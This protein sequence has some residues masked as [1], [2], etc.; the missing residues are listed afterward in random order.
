M[1]ESI[2]SVI[3][4]SYNAAKY[5]PQAINSVLAQT[6]R[7]FEIIV[8]DDGSTDDTQKVI[9]E[10]SDS[11]IY[12]RQPNS[13]PSAARNK[14]IQ[15]SRG[16][17]IAFLD[18]DDLWVPNKLE[19]Q[20]IAFQGSK[21]CAFVCS[22]WSYFDGEERINVSTLK[23][24][25]AWN[26]KADFELMIRENFVLTSS[27]M[28]DR[29]MLSKAGLFWEKLRG[30]EDRH[31]WLRLLQHGD[32]VV[33]KEILAYKRS[34]PGNVSSTLNFVRD[35]IEMVQDVLTWDTVIKNPDRKS[36]LEAR[37]RQIKAGLGYALAKQKNYEE[38]ADLYLSLFYDGFER[39]HSGTRFF[40][41]SV[42]GKIRRIRK[43][44]E[45]GK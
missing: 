14:G 10:Y 31:M 18:A 23:N 45:K 28:V 30:A 21:N 16:D 12:I 20:L 22:D 36:I 17:Y 29:Q 43:Q 13:G 42:L 26:C 34:H 4:P 24:Y 3:I 37:Y 41:Y 19:D 8:I 32:A 33:C 5:L 2:I 35:Q 25:E 15:I 44:G 6:Y 1:S 27:V 38:S 7:Q 11:V 39:W 9:T 40:I